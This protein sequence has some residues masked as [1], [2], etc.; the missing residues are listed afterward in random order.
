MNLYVPDLITDMIDYLSIEDA[1]FVSSTSRKYHNIIYMIRKLIYPATNN[2]SKFRKLYHLSLWSF[3]SNISNL[4]NLTYLNL[5]KNNVIKD[6]SSLVN[7]KYLS[8]CFNDK[9]RDIS[10]LINLEILDLRCNNKIRDVSKL[11]NLKKL[12]LYPGQISTIKLPD[13]TS[14]INISSCG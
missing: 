11:I 8:L 7:L 6:I 14:K 13:D 9:I 10:R 3:G 12:L 2:I 5:G 4:T 1:Y